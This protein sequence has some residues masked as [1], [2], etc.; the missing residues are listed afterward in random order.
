[1][2]QVFGQIMKLPLEAFVYSMEMLVKTMQG[3]QLIVSRGIDLM[4]G[5][6]M[7][8]LVHASGSE[9]DIAQE[10]TAAGSA[11][12][13]EALQPAPQE[14]GG[15]MAD[16]NLNDDMLK[17]VRY[18]VLFIKRDLEHA[19]PEFEELVHDNMD[20]ASFSSWTI[21]RFIQNFTNADIPEKWRAKRYPK[22]SGE[23]QPGD[24]VDLPEEDKKYLRVYFEVLDR[25]PRERFKYEERQI[26]VLEDIRDRMPGPA[27]P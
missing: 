11:Q 4:A 6:K 16:R 8:T 19:F 2:M 5:E 26:E 12:C 9:S 1:M 7:Q 17:L 13:V 25:Y 24:Q 15:L 27:R 20:E 10:G 22:P 14:E 23:G 3:V 18:K 21:A